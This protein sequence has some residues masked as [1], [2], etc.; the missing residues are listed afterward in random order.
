MMT[1][2][3]AA[4][5]LFFLLTAPGHGADADGQQRLLIEAARK[6]AKMIFY[7]S[8]E[9]EF[10]RALTSGF[11]AKYP[12]IKTDIFRSTHDKILSRMNIERQTSTYVADVV[13]VGEFETY[14][15]QKKGFLQPYKSPNAAVYPEGFKDPAGY[16]TDLYDNLIVSAFNT[17]RVKRDELPKRWDD[18]LHPRWKGR[19]V[20]DQNEDRWF[21]NTLHV[22]GEKRGLEFMQALAKQEVAIRSGRSLITQLLSAGEFDFQIVAYWYRPYL[23]KKQGAPVDWIGLEPAIVAMH[24]I[25]IVE[26]AP[27]S[28]AARLFIDFALSDE[29]QKIFLK[30]GRE[31]AMPGL[32]PE[33]YPSHLKMLPSRV[34]LAEKLD[35]YS[36]QYRALFVR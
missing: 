22:M 11:E 36:R 16:W 13:S 32:R 8:V 9:T 1:I 30:R 18:L 2:L 12:F 6:D 29:G 23:M 14:H 25:S 35:D 31:P 34:Q 24:P 26:K 4:T 28:S 19:M 15:M 27:H 10:A 17:N 20:L 21:A 5:F 3:T 7:T 33:G